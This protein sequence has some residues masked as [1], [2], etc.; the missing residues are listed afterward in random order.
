M[1]IVREGDPLIKIG[2]EFQSLAPEY[3]IDLISCW[4]VVFLVR[5]PLEASLVLITMH[6]RTLCKI[7]MKMGGS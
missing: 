5:S 3:R 4:N 7:R 2:I 1:K 6:L